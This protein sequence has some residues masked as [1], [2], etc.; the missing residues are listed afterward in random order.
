MDSGAAESVAPKSMA[1]QFLLTDSPASRAGVFYTAANGGRL[2]NLGQQEIPVAFANGIRAMTTFQIAEVSRPLMSVAKI[3]EL[4]NR[5]LFG[6]NGGVIVNLNTGQAT[7]FEKED[8]VYVF[9][10]WIPPL[11][12]TPFG[13]QP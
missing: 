8:G 1:R 2:D 4:G 6:A 10:M 3:C 11:A 7:P 13:R 9:S 5:V 12:E